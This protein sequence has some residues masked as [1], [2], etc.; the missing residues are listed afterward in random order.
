M[1]I[2]PAGLTVDVTH[3]VNPLTLQD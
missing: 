2:V 3:V 1:L